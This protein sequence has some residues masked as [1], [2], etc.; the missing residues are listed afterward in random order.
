VIDVNV[1]VN[2]SLP[3]W[4]ARLSGFEPTDPDFAD[5]VRES[6]DRQRIMA[7]IGAQLVR[8]EPGECEI[9]LPFKP[10]LSQQHGYY[11]GGIIGTIAESAG[12]YAAFTLMTMHGR[13]DQ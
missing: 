5:R 3:E 12:G 13:P 1:N 8:L 4:R 10:E 2:Y 11:H 6:F 7:L 9:Q